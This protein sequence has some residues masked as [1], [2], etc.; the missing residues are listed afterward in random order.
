MEIKIQFVN[1]KVQKSFEKLGLG[2]NEE[3]QLKGYIERAFR[4]IGENAF[5]G[6][7]IPKRLIPKEYIKKFGIKN[8][9]KYNLPGAWRLLYSLENDKFQVIS[10]VLEW[11]D[12]KNYERRFNY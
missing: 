10:I 1:E 11:L 2:T 5:C 9:F 12:H 7:Q 8:V 3:K 6:I 4:D